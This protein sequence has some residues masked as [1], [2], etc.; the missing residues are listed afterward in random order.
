MSAIEQQIDY[1][2]RKC[3]GLPYGSPEWYDAHAMGSR[4]IR[5]WRDEYTLRAV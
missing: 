1:Y 3:A 2:R 4:W 5:A